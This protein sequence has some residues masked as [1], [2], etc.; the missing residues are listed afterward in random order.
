M[1][2]RRAVHSNDPEIVAAS[3][4]AIIQLGDVDAIADLIGVIERSDRAGEHARKALVALTA[5]DFGSS[6]RK[7]RKWYEASRKRHRVEWLIDGLTH[8]EDAIR[9]TAINDLRRLTGEYFGYHHDLPRREREASAARWVAW[10][11]DAGQ[12]RF[13]YDDDERHRPTGVLP[14]RHD[15]T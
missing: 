8:K 9:E 11:Q 3:T 5:Q 2:A 14:S 7:W 1:R 15:P 10:W 13:V 12:R 4:A 6:E